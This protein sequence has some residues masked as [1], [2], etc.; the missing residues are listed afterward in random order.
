MERIEGKVSYAPET[1]R[2]V[3]TSLEFAIHTLDPDF[4]SMNVLRL[5]PGVPFSFAPQFACVRPTGERP[6][7]GG[8]YD[9]S[10][11]EE[12]RV[13]DLRSNHPI[14]RA[15]EGCGSVNPPYMHPGRCFDILSLA[16]DM[17]NTKNSQKGKRQTKI[18]VDTRFDRYLHEEW[19][20]GSRYYSLASFEDI[21]Q[22]GSREF[23]V[24]GEPLDR[25]NG[26]PRL[27]AET[28]VPRN[29]HSSVPSG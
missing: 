1:D 20:R 2:D 18:I 6:I 29:L 27:N 9:A 12:N 7:H 24:K 19:I 8:H 13:S 10:W 4:L 15:F 17:V 21:E 22:V 16:V 11:Y 25:L 14:L 3:R 28:S 5:L 23:Q 26:P